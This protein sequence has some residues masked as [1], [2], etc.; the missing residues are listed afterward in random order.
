MC[1]PI[2][3][4]VETLLTQLRCCQASATEARV[5]ANV[6]LLR[7]ENSSLFSSLAS[8]M[9]PKE[10]AKARAPT[11]ERP[12]L[13]IKTAVFLWAVSERGGRPYLLALISPV[14]MTLRLGVCR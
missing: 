8:L 13:Q 14:E 3:N 10:A 5:R 1:F 4:T 6:A 7:T 12:Y 9:A 2:I 11:R